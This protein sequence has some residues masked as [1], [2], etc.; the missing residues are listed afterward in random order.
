MTAT[1]EDVQLGPRARASVASFSHLVVDDLYGPDG[2]DAYEAIAGRDATEVREIVAHTSR[3][4]GAILDLAAGSG[5]LTLPLLTLRRPVVALDLSPA[6]LDIL[7]KKLARR[8]SARRLCRTVHADMTRFSLEE[9]FG[10]IVVGTTSISLLP[11]AA[12]RARLLDCV[13]THLAPGGTLVLTTVG[14]SGDRRSDEEQVTEVATDAGA[15]SVFEWLPA[16]SDRRFISVV[17]VT[18]TTARLFTSSIAVLDPE[19]LRAE[20][21]RAGFEVRETAPLGPPDGRY[22]D[23]LLVATL[24]RAAGSS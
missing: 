12:A 1:L 17:T 21:E 3:T 20:L 23:T 11:D 8:D 13:R 5:R 15:Y 6:M 19:D 14:V 18:G 22:R 10:C 4:T 2:A 7:D 9:R 24:S 16:G